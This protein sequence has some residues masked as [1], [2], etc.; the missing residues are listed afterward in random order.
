MRRA[1]A[2]CGWMKC[3]VLANP[4]YFYL[5]DVLRGTKVVDGRSY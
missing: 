2:P 1:C 5:W 3:V 4:G